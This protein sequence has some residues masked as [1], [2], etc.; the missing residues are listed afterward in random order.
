VNGDG[1]P[2][3]TV[4]Q[5]GTV[6]TFLGSADETYAS[7]P[8]YFGAGPAPNDIL[9]M[10]LHGQSPKAGLPDLV[11][12]DGSGGVTVLINTTK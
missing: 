6:Q 11:L 3:I 1:I 5:D 8:F 4:V 12:P 10:N 2:D 7:S 9:T